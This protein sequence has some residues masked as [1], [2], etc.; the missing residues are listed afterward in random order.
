MDRLA[1]AHDALTAELAD[2]EAQAARVR[3][4]LAALDGGTPAVPATQQE[5]PPRPVPA[6]TPTR[7]TKGH[8]PGMRDAVI[9]VIAASSEPMSAAMVLKALADADFSVD[10]RNPYN[11]V[12]TTLSRL[13]RLGRARR[14]GAG[15][16]TVPDS[17]QAEPVVP[18]GRTLD[19]PRQGDDGT[20]LMT[21]GSG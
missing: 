18:L 1:T 16:Y 20:R 9:E 14:V 12:A 10:A 7:A 11:A 8:T 17:P 2:L 5:P 15:L 19:F 4:A 21:A 6:A 13:E 3:A